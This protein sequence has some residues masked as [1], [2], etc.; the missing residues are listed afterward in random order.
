MQTTLIRIFI[1]LKS[2]SHGLSRKHRKFHDFSAQKQVVSKKKKRSSPNLSL[3]F[4]PK[5]EIQ[6]FFQTASLH[7][8]H[9]FSTQF[10]LGGGLFSIFNQKSGSK[11]PKMC[12]F[13]YFT[14]QWGGC[15]PSLATLL[16][17]TRNEGWHPSRMVAYVTCLT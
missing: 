8:L 10:P 11:A 5:S 3:N 9:N 1:V 2:E 15:S 7:I 6:T 17:R 16:H 14:G 13:A 4:R 12:D